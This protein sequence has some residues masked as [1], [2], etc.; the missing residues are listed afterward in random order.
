[1]KPD[2]R[3]VEEIVR[4][5]VFVNGHV[6]CRSDKDCN[7]KN[8][9]NEC[10]SLVSIFI[11]LLRTERTRAEAAEAE[12]ERLRTMNYALSQGKVKELIEENM[13][14]KDRLALHVSTDPQNV[15]GKLD[16]VIDECNR[17]QAENASMC[18]ELPRLKEVVG[19]LREALE[20]FVDDRHEER[21]GLTKSLCDFCGLRWP[22][23]HGQAKKVLNDTFKEVV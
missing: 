21:K 10:M 16:S 3:S 2:E 19:R 23:D 12:V 22:C 4:E 7:E 15:C 6:A 1:M 11:R 14:L 20:V 13:Q 5:E 18:D 17:L 9:C 8:P